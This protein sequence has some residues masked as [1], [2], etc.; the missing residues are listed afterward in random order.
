MNQDHDKRAWHFLT[1]TLL[2]L[3]LAGIPG[4]NALSAAEQPNIVLLLAD[5]LG[6]GELGCQGNREIPTPH[7]DSI[8]AG[9][10]RFTNGYVTAAFCSAS[11]A[12][13]LT[14]RYQTRFGYEFNPTGHRN[15]DPAAGLPASHTTIADQLQAIGYTTALFGQWPLGGT[16][17]EKRKGGREGR[18]RRGGHRTRDE[19]VVDQAEHKQM[20]RTDVTQRHTGRAVVGA[21]D[22][23]AKAD[24][25]AQDA[26]Q[27]DLLQHVQQLRNHRRHGHRNHTAHPHQRIRRDQGGRR[28]RHR[29]PW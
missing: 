24:R 17:A 13:L 7:I 29:G 5:D 23:S 10:V 21:E 27:D 25:G 1:P 12:G 8:A 9:G 11:R 2:L 22:S 3:V 26:L 4:W 16:L 18:R 20:Q 19:E 28:G 15:E 14:G 6:Y